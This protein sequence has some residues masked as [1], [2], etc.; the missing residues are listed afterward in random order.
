MRKTTSIIYFCT[1]LLLVACGNV[2]PMDTGQNT[3]D[4]A[5]ITKISNEYLISQ[6]PSNQAKEM[7]RKHEEITAV[8]AVNTEDSIVIAIEV[9]HHERFTLA[10]TR[11]KYKKEMEDKF[12]DKKVEFSTDKKIVLELEKLEQD[13]TNNTITKKELEKKVKQIIKLTKEQT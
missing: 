5:D 10:E 13:I 8:R 12:K 7:L 1:T 3:D 2:Q 4:F 11:K 9:E 6:K